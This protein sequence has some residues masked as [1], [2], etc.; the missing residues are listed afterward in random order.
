[1]DLAAEASLVAVFCEIF[2]NVEYFTVLIPNQRGSVP[3]NL[4]QRIM[5]Q[6]RP[7]HLVLDNRDK[8]GQLKTGQALMAI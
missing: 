1:M 8:A 5:K 4:E 6:S 3:L 7:L 2:T